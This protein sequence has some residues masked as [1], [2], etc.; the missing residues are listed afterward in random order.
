MGEVINLSGLKGPLAVVGFVPPYYPHRGNLRRSDKE[1]ALLEALAAVAAKGH[2]EFGEEITYVEYFGGI[3]DMSFLGFRGARGACRARGEHAGMGK[4]LLASSGGSVRPMSPWRTSVRRKD[5]HKDTER[6]EL[7][8]SLRVRRNFCAAPWSIRSL[9][10]DRLDG[11]GR[12]GP[13]RKKERR[14]PVT[15]G[16]GGMEQAA[17]RW[18]SASTRFFPLSGGASGKPSH[19]QRKG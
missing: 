6:L 15:N 14:C 3:T 12:R 18:T 19:S 2:E 17:L 16:N 8:F 10:E 7:D 11:P 9:P 5:A 4:A 1:H 13:E